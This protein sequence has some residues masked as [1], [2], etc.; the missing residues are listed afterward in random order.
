MS[1]SGD[2][3]SASSVPFSSSS[4][5][6]SSSSL[7]RSIGNLGLG[8]AIAIALG[9]LVLLSTLLFASYFFCRASS[10]RRRIPTPNATV[11]A[12][13]GAI[14][15]RSVFSAED[16]AEEGP[17]FGLSAGLDSSDIASTRSSLSLWRRRRRGRGTVYVPS[18]YATTEKGRC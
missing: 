5:S 12:S 2:L 3:P 13:G 17:G 6:S 10:R 1:F 16:D 7:S 14:L 18:A 9:L 4:S 11:D 8:Y 15:P